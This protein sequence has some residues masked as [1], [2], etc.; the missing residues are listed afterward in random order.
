MGQN[1]GQEKSR[2]KKTPIITGDI[3]A[4]GRMK[5]IEPSNDGTTTRCV[6]HFTT[7]AIYKQDVL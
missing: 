1:V 7:F 2:Y 6:N 3:H 4:M 5:G